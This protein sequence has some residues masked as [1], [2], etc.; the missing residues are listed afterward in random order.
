MIE[1]VERSCLALFVL[2][3]GCM[4]P[5][6][7]A[8]REK[9]R[10]TNDSESVRKMITAERGLQMLERRGRSG[11]EWLAIF[12]EEDFEGREPPRRREFLKSLESA[13]GFELIAASDARILQTVNDASAP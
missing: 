7:L 12:R 1:N 5:V 9:V 3:A 10:V 4:G 6:R 13:P 2:L 11:A 8:E